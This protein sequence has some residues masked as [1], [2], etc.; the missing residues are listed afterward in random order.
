MTDFIK[1]TAAAAALAL[2]AGC[3]EETSQPA[4]EPPAQGMPAVGSASD[5]TSFEGARA[6]QAEG[7]LRALG[8][9]SIR[10]E[11]LTTYWFNRDTGACARITTDQG[12]YSDVTMVPAEDC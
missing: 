11:G 2:L 10:S 8:Y 3:V 5:V 4:Q 7:G 1:L 9:E 6:G 12:R